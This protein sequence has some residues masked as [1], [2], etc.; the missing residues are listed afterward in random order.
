MKRTEKI[1]CSMTSFDNIKHLFPVIIKNGSDYRD[2]LQH[3]LE[4]YCSIL[5]TRKEDISIINSCKAISKQILLI[6]DNMRQGAHSTAYRQLENILNDKNGKY[7]ITVDGLIQEQEGYFYRMR[8]VEDR[9]NVGAKEMFHIPFNMRN[10]VTTERYSFPGLPCLYLGYSVYV[11]WE[12][13]GRPEFSRV[14]ISALKTT[15]KLRLLDLRAP[16]YHRW[17]Q[18]NKKSIP[19]LLACQVVVT[20][21]EAKYKSEY[22]IPQLMMEYIITNHE[23]IDGILYSSVFK[24]TQ[25]EYPADKFYNLA[26]PAIQDSKVEK[27]SPKLKNLFLVT[28]PTCEEYERLN[29]HIGVYD[30]TTTI[31]RTTVVQ[32]RNYEISIFKEIEDSLKNDELYPLHTIEE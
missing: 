15:R 16:I 19:L 20:D 6:V 18:T 21:K 27:Y 26:L 28:D 10:I 1:Q 30:I 11:C 24:D 2:C 14:M 5:E 25:F 22:I 23:N 29:R 7:G 9:R 32:N 4:E 8:K 31:D 12:E 13:M 17:N 3:S